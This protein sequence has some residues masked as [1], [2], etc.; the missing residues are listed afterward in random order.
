[1]GSTGQARGIWRDQAPRPR[2]ES[3][4]G[5]PE[6]LRIGEGQGSTGKARQ[7]GGEAWPT[8]GNSSSVWDRLGA[9]ASHTEAWIPG[10]L[11]QQRGLPGKGAH[12]RCT[13]QGFNS[14]PL[15]GPRASAWSE[16]PCQ[17]DV[18]R[19][20]QGATELG[21]SWEVVMRKRQGLTACT[22]RKA[23]KEPAAGVRQAGDQLHG[24][25]CKQVLLKCLASLCYHCPACPPS[26]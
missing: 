22:S 16:S 2:C 26:R 11:G 20:R 7:G 12:P 5:T 1:M 6:T 13:E 23:S 17:R 25:A 15:P 14:R 24:L 3:S 21:G 9:L 8:A 18:Q 19:C 4:G 10:A